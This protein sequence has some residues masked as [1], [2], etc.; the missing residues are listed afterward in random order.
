MSAGAGPVG[1]GRPCGPIVIP[2]SPSPPKVIGKKRVMETD[3]LIE[4]PL[5][6]RRTTFPIQY[7]EESFHTPD[8]PTKQLKTPESSMSDTSPPGS[9]ATQLVNEL[10]KLNLTKS[11]ENGLDGLTPPP[12]SPNLGT[13]VRAHR[14]SPPSLGSDQFMKG[15]V[16]VDRTPDHGRFRRMKAFMDPNTFQGNEDWS[17]A[18]SKHDGHDGH[19]SCRWFRLWPMGETHQ[20]LRHVP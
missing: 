14:A 19:W 5:K 4:T 1:N 16:C 18:P 20:I 8:R 12:P 11:K 6:S 10:G 9:I 15:K 2:D 17:G 7:G 13:T 3:P